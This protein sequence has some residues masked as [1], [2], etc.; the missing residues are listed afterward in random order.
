MSDDQFV[1][2]DTV[3]DEMVALLQKIL[4]CLDGEIRLR[5]GEILEEAILTRKILEKGTE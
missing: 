5:L 1:R 4:D 2:P 3:M